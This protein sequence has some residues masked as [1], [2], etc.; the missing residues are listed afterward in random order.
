MNQPEF[1]SIKL[2]VAM[3]LFGALYTNKPDTWDDSD[4]VYQSLEL[5]DKFLKETKN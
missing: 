4:V 1:P 3:A 5:A 2:Q